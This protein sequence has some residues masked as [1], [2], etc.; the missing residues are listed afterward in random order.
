MSRKVKV[1]ENKNLG[2]LSPLQFLFL[3]IIFQHGDFI[4][5]YKIRRT[6]Q[7]HLPEHEP[8]TGAIYKTLGELREGKLVKS[9]RQKD[10]RI[11]HYRITNKGKKKLREL[12]IKRLRFLQFM[13]H[14]CAHRIKK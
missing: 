13:Q 10:R 11:K 6:I 9:E 2:K 12:Y 4:S 7:D 8:S 14:C 5:V 3:M 1:N